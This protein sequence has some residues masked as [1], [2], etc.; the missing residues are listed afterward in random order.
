ML[1][2]KLKHSIVGQAM[3]VELG[4]QS[5][6][7]WVILKIISHQLFQM[8]WFAFLLSLKNNFKPTFTPALPFYAVSDLINVISAV[9]DACSVLYS[10]VVFI[11]VLPCFSL[12][13]WKGREVRSACFYLST[14]GCGHCLTHQN[15]FFTNETCWTSN[16]FV[17]DHSHWLLSLA[18]ERTKTWKWR[19]NKWQSHTQ[20][21]SQAACASFIPRKF[22]TTTCR[23]GVRKWRATNQP[24]LSTTWQENCNS[25]TLSLS[26]FIIY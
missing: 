9:L 2:N 15:L 1:S 6:L 25:P 12:G 10:K 5:Q 8:Y 22:F 17:W 11:A 26:T 18:N 19:K 21:A 16:R 20:A 7:N 24:H 14:Y 13:T 3:E 23:S 4:P